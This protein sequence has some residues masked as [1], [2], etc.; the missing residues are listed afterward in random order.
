MGWWPYFSPDAGFPLDICPGKEAAAYIPINVTLW[1]PN[2]GNATQNWNGTAS[3]T[4]VVNNPGLPPTAT[5][6]TTI[7][8]QPGPHEYEILVYAAGNRASTF[9]SGFQ[10]YSAGVELTYIGTDD[11]IT[12]KS[13]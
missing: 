13:P 1:P 8:M 12:G 5:T 11:P 4:N 2:V 6:F 9:D 3:L 10:E 7:T